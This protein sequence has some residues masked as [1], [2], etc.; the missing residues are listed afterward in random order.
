LK[1]KRRPRSKSHT[2]AE[3]EEEGFELQGEALTDILKAMEAREVL[4]ENGR[5]VQSGDSQKRW[6]RR[7]LSQSSGDISNGYYSCLLQVRS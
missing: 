7:S 4:P 3:I 5:G 1:R 6:H 2:E